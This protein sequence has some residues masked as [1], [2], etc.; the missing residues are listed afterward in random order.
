MVLAADRETPFQKGFGEL[1]RIPQAQ[2][3]TLFKGALVCGNAAGYGAP[4]ADTANFTHV[5]GVSLRQYPAA[6]A[7]A[8]GTVVAELWVGKVALPIGSLTIADRMRA[9]YVTD[10]E[11][12]QLTVNTNG[13]R[14][15][16]FLG[17]HETDATLGWFFI[18]PAVNRMP[19]ILS[20]DASDLG[21]AQTLVNEIKN[22]INNYA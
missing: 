5:E 7:T 14:A 1:V 10:D 19:A 22:A 12:V 21:T 3:T 8:N 20:P 4:A 2:A 17:P 16:V 6:N 9:V 18:H 13:I 11:N 15:G